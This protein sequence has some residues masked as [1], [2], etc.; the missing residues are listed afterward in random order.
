MIKRY[1]GKRVIGQIVEVQPKDW[2]TAI[3]LPVKTF[4][5][6]TERKV[7]SNTVQSIYK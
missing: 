6:A 1:I 4:Y 2:L 7:W 3:F 5:G